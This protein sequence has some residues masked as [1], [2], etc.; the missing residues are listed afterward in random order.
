VEDDSQHASR[1][2]STHS[3]HRR[4][5]RIVGT[6]LVTISEQKSIATIQPVPLTLTFNKR[7]ASLQQPASSLTLRKEAEGGWSRRRQ[8]VSLDEN[9]IHRHQKKDNE[10]TFG[11]SSSEQSPQRP[12]KETLEPAQPPFP[13]PERVKT[14]EGVPS[15]RGQVFRVGRNEGIPVDSTR[16]PLLRQLRA[17]SS[18]LL[19]RVLG[20]SR[21]QLPSQQRTFRPPPSGHGDRIGTHP[22]HTAPVAIQGDPARDLRH[23]RSG[24]KGPACSIQQSGSRPYSYEYPTNP[25]PSD[26]NTQDTDEESTP[27]ALRHVQ[28]PSERALHAASG[29]AIP[30]SPL[31]AHKLAKSL[32]AGRTISTPKSRQ[33]TVGP[34]VA[35]S[36]PSHSAQN[37]T[38]STMELIQQFPA[39]PSRS[40]TLVTPDD[41]INGI[42]R[43]SSSST[44][45]RMVTEPVMSGG[46][47]SAED[48]NFQ[49]TWMDG[50]HR[51]MHKIKRKPL[52]IEG[53]P[54]EGDAVQAA[55][56]EALLTR[57]LSRERSIRG[58]SLS[59]YRFSGTPIY[60]HD[61]T[62]L[63]SLDEQ[64][65]TTSRRLLA[66]RMML[67]A[68]PESA[69]TG[70]TRYFSARSISLGNQAISPETSA[71]Q[72]QERAITNGAMRFV[73][74]V[75][76]PISS[77]VTS[78]ITSPVSLPTSPA[79]EN[80]FPMTPVTVT[81]A[82]RAYCRHR[83]K[84][85]QRE[86][87]LY[88]RL[89]L[90]GSVHAPT[91][92]IPPRLPSDP[93]CVHRQP[94]VRFQHQPSEESFRRRNHIS[95][96]MKSGTWR[97]RMSKTKC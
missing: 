10:S 33:S 28:S 93:N 13:P 12:A 96:R 81:Q 95:R 44:Q 21:I 38:M 94:S 89:G 31:R 80:D 70:N 49:R 17:R 50:H 52:N 64:G 32:K 53:M 46:A 9:A 97:T 47:D 63:R 5:I 75:S 69:L 30:I 78:P 55:A 88:H 26:S 54:T 72:E 85:M 48:N 4:P 86:Q 24:L 56:D 82:S 58:E 3:L 18:Q 16:Q 62:S 23:T 43:P 14:P 76:S 1:S 6:Q 22:F 39:P 68:R 61:A 11:I 45:E 35:Q 73:P 8:C 71:V 7:I 92:N 74:S 20:D 19:R 65:D 57:N 42:A 83:V 91:E 84:R 36:V 29:N 25:V 41:R 37:G 34:S 66:P 51:S 77:Y 87:S 2:E 59:R 40:V 27:S 90:D 15:W 67:V 79:N 60:D